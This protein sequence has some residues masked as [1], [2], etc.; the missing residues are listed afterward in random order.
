MAHRTRITAQ[1]QVRGALALDGKTIEPA[2]C[3]TDLAAP[4][5]G[6][7]QLE[8]EL[9]LIGMKFR[10]FV[11]VIFEQVQQYIEHS[12]F[13]LSPSF[14]VRADNRSVPPT[15]AHATPTATE[16]RKRYRPSIHCDRS[17]C[18]R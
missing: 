16:W 13:H 4:E 9:F 2:E 5:P 12:L 6:L 18:R 11:H 10:S 1:R 7:T 15:P 14:R 3:L 17:Q 8:R